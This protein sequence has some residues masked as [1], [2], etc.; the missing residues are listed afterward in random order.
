M[1]KK[2]QRFLIVEPILY[3]NL[4]KK[5]DAFM[6]FC[7]RYTGVGILPI[8]LF[9]FGTLEYLSGN[10]YLITFSFSL[11]FLIFTW[12]AYGYSLKKLKDIVPVDVYFTDEKNEPLQGVR[13]LKIN[14]DNIRI[15]SNNKTLII[16]KGEVLKIEMKT[17][18]HLQ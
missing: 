14:D 18:E 7:A 2:D 15:R 13:I 8:I 12:S 17:P 3:L 4:D 9:Y 6:S 10:I 16:N 5:T 11:I 1:F